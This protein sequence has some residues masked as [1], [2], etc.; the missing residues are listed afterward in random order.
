MGAEHNMARRIQLRRDIAA[1]WTVANPLLAQGEI[2]LDLT[3]KKI[4]IGDGVTL[5]NALAYWDDD[6]TNLE[7]YATEQY[8]DDAVG[9]IVIP[10]VSNFITAEDIPSIPA[11]ISDLTDTEGLLG[12]GGGDR[13]VNG[14]YFAVLEPDGVLITPNAV[15]AKTRIS[16]ETTDLSTVYETFQERTVQL[17]DQFAAAEYTGQGYPASKDSYEA[18]IRAKALN[19]LIPDAWLPIALS[20]RNAY[21]VWAGS[22]TA[23]S[24]DG[25]GFVIA[26]GNGTSW[27]FDEATGLR[28]PDNTFQTTA[29]TGSE[30]SA[31]QLINATETF[32]ISEQGDVVFSGD[33]GGR[34]R[35]LV[36]D[37][38]AEA[39]GENSTVRQDQQGLSVRAYTEAG[40]GVYAAPVNI[41]TNQSENT[42]VW[43]FD[44]NGDLSLP[45]GGTIREDEVTDNPTI[46]LTP[47]NPDVESQKLVIKGGMAYSN[48]ENGITISTNNLNVVSG[49]IVNFGVYSDQYADQQ[50][51]WWVD[52]YSP[53]QEFSPDNGTITL[54]QFGGA[55]IEFTVI[56][57]TV[58]LRIYVADALY[59]AYANSKGAVSVLVNGEPQDS[60][61]LH[62]T[63]GDLQETSVILGTD[64][65]NVRTKN[66]GSIELTSADYDNQQTY[67]LNFKN[68]VLKI[69]S[70]DSVNDE[71][72]YIKAED[73]LYLD[74]LDDDI[75]LRANDDVRIKVGYN[76]DDDFSESEWVF[77]SDG[78]SPYI[79]FPDGTEQYTAYTGGNENILTTVAKTGTTNVG[80]GEVATV[81]ISPSNN[82]NLTPGV[83]QI[84]LGVLNVG[85]FAVDVTVAQNGD[86]SGVVVNSPG[87][88]TVGTS[89]VTIG[90]AVGGTTGVDDIT[91]T[92]STLTNVVDAA[93]PL[94]LTKSVNKL[95]DGYYTLANGVE[96]QIMYLVRQPNAGPEVAIS[97][98]T[99]RVGNN[100]YTDIA[101]FPFNGY[102]TG[103]MTT[104]IFTDGAWQ[105]DNGS[106]D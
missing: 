70:T 50:F 32:T 58:P 87:G 21:F 23:L 69:S 98:A 14:E 66:D 5:W 20:L 79:E 97:V 2:G 77:R 96:G 47:A 57:D 106:W 29:Y 54:N 36:W 4:K 46:E 64:E 99:G 45:K 22:Y 12:G 31:N 65:H 28:F 55:S 18:L 84:A 94:D 89:I 100:V 60:Y 85:S 41:V 15:S 68:N 38:G 78:E 82:T 90:G 101:F 74:A 26:N 42:K 56:D 75:H 73:D 88:F 25:G 103:N 81:S 44:G 80:T 62:L 91:T 76:F 52:T 61:H 51:Y 24:V 8:V 9:A 43:T 39:G 40:D 30:N 27:R 95:T 92:I 71:D 10:D 105:S 17:A 7:G 13:L 1:A 67:R 48:T 37:Y 33:E 35:G 34:N 86:I 93:T 63:T 3:N 72:L 102:G 6:E 16:I 104:L 11:D 19:P 49:N 53:G 59:N 83:Y